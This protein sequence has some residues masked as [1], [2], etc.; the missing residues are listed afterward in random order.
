VKCFLQQ[1]LS[2]S[3]WWI[4]WWQSQS[5]RTSYHHEGAHFASKPYFLLV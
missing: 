3:I 4:G 5:G 1:L 2:W